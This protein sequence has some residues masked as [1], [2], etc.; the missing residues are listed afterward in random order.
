MCTF[1]KEVEG[2]WESFLTP[3]RRVFPEVYD[4]K[5]PLPGAIPYGLKR[6]DSYCWFLLLKVLSRLLTTSLLIPVI[7]VVKSRLRTFETVTPV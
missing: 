4:E 6:K 5:R 7:K 1:D 3:L 2:G